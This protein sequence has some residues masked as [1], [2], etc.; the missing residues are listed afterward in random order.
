MNGMHQR[1]PSRGSENRQRMIRAWIIL[2]GIIL[3]VVG[4]VAGVRYFGGRVNASASQLPCRA[5]QQVTPFGE[6]VLYYDGASIH[7]LTETG[8]VRWSFQIGSG[9]SFAVGERSMAAWVGNQLYLVDYAGRTTYKDAMPDTV[10]FARVGKQYAAVVVGADTQPTLM[11]K[12]LLGT[13]VDEEKEAFSGMMLLDVGFYGDQGQYMWTTV[14]D[15]YGTAANTIL[16]TFEVGRMNTGESSLGEAIT[17]RILYENGKLRVISTRQMRTFT[18]Q[19]IENT[20]ETMLVYG[21][22]LLDYEVPRNGSA[23][24]L[25]A[26]TSQ[27]NSSYAISE[28]RLLSGATDRRYTLPSTCAGGTVYRQTVY[29]F[30]SQYI[31]RAKAGDQRFTATDM[32]IQ[33]KEVT[34][35]L[36]RLDNGKVLLACGDEVYVVTLPT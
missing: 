11:V 3:A 19:G 21:W 8:A 35:F 16:N 12:D 28:M 20:S 23:L 32:P 6:Y 4:V 14:L 24:M 1:F 7:C 18:Y 9:A 27:T 2:L 10:Q 25:F 36:G 26:P 30:S 13:Q 34:D 22:R 17:Y 5:N 15:V 31:Y 33:G 29:A